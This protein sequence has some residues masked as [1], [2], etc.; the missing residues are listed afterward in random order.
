VNVDFRVACNFFSNLKVRK[1]K[2]RFGFQGVYSLLRLWGMTATNYPS[3]EYKNPDFDLI[4]EV[5]EYPESIQDFFDFLLEENFIEK[6]KTGFK[7]HEWEVH[8][9]Y[10]S[11]AEKRSESARKA[12][13]VRW[14]KDSDSKS[15]S[16]SDRSQPRDPPYP[17]PKP[18]PKPN[19]NPNP[20]K[21]TCPGYPDDFL[22]FWDAYPRREG[23]SIA[24]KTW[25]A[26]LKEG[27]IPEEIILAATKY[28]NRCQLEQREQRFIKQPAT[29]LGPDWREHLK[30]QSQAERD[31]DAIA[32]WAE[33]DDSE[34][35][36]I[37]V[38][39]V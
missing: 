22:K 37:E 15:D 31:Q 19:P 3:G 14:G 17:N 26:R 6:T 39:K 10:A 29:F 24:F 35:G 30:Y 21:K 7:I 16:E 9:G 8:N 36:V 27:A 12:N 25:K 2:R 23:K 4:A 38:E 20:K 13:A 1:L 34:K 32:K 33:E 11:T 28:A 18:S 5:I